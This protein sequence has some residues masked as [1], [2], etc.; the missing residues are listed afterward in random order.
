MSRDKK[1]CFLHAGL[2][3]APT[4]EHSEEN[5]IPPALGEIFGCVSKLLKVSS[6]LNEYVR[7]DENVTTAQTLMGGNTA[8]TVR[9]ASS[10]V[11]K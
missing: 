1:N 4:A 9:P 3:S 2:C 10:A 6:S 11:D 7:V 5:E 8:D